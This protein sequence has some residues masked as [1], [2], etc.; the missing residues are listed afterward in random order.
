MAA[1]L[2]HASALSIVLGTV[3]ALVSVVSGAEHAS[4]L[5]Q[6]VPVHFA[7]GDLQKDESKTLSAAVDV[8]MDAWLTDVRLHDGGPKASVA[9]HT[10]LCSTPTGCIALV[11]GAALPK[12]LYTLTVTATAVGNGELD[13]ESWME[14]RLVY[15]EARPVVLPVPDPGGNAAPGPPLAQTGA[16]LFTPVLSSSIALLVVGFV[17]VLVARRR[18]RDDEPAPLSPA[19]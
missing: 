12:G 9:W 8:P 11:A 6:V 5:P 1:R 14:G 13:E 3:L 10:T 7:F 17:L 18:R 19:G 4:A 16:A 2:R 15:S